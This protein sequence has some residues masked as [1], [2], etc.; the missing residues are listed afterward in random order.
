MRRIIIIIFVLV[1]VSAI[2]LP[3]FGQVS[4]AATIAYFPVIYGPP[5]EPPAW[6]GP[7]GGY[8]IAIAIAPSQP[9]TIY[10]G[11]WGSGVF[12]ST[13][14]GAT[15]V[16]KS[17]GLGTP[18]I[19]SMAVD[20][21]DPQTVYAGTYKGKVYKTIDGAEN[22]FQ[23]SKNIQAEAIVY[24]MVID[25]I[26]PE[27]IY[28]GTRGIANNGG[29]PWNGV[30]YRTTDA[31]ANWTAVLTNVG[32]S[33]D[34]DWAYGLTLH[35]RNPDWIYA[36][37][38]EHGVFRSTNSGLNWYA[39]NSGI[40]N[41]SARG[42]V[43]DPNSPKQDPIVYMGAWKFDG[44]FKTLN[45][46]ESWFFQS[47]SLGSRI[48]SMSIDPLDSENVYASLFPGGVL[49]TTNGGGNWSVA[50]LHD[51]EVASTVVNT[52]NTKLLYAGTNGDGLFMSVDRGNTW[53]HSQ[54][55][56]N[57]TRVSA[58]QVSA[59]NSQ[60]LFVG[61]YGD[62]L[63]QTWDGGESWSSLGSGL[64]GEKILGLETNPA[65]PNFLF[66]LTEA[67]GLYRCNLNSNCWLPISINFPSTALIQEPFTENHPFALPAL[68]EP[69]EEDEKQNPATTTQ[70]PPLLSL[71]FA[72]SNPQIAY[73][74]TS[75]AG[76]YKSSDNG[77]TWQP[78]SLTS[79]KIV[80][81]AVSSQDS[82]NVFV[83]TPGIVL[84][85]INGGL[86]WTNLNLNGLGIY[87]LTSDSST[88]IYAGTNDG[89]YRYSTSGWARLG[90]AGIDVTAIR[91]H[92]TKANHL[93]AGTTNGLYISHDGGQTWEARPWQLSGV[94][95]QSISFDLNAPNYVYVS[96]KTHGV[97]R[98]HDPY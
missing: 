33:S 21:K 56:L 9:N 37:T 87:V 50:G 44:V 79:E 42:V 32:G 81:I 3:T 67:G 94:T 47:S 75:G 25:P 93:Y 55:G 91:S 73:L 41:L 40:T 38:H 57:A 11:T 14:S 53:N 77:S 84:Q 17:H 30:L 83:A 5:P 35:P 76:L 64:T 68:L 34:Q 85:S 63:W 69:W 27:N 24:S 71:V 13:D 98:I 80:S 88:N 45:G 39:V 31:G 60:R 15:W 4:D 48:Y 43:V 62:G 89:V 16:W 19:N 96:T 8:I 49:K 70:I 65:D 6:I 28:I 78:T 26:D 54:K 58:M 97:M 23:S 82:E 7:Y 90:L 74:G 12:K 20:P 66:A 10:A 22:W 18:F 72:P 59:Y 51:L 29:P 2:V 52:V 61:I 1:S 86:N 95:I 36:A 92:P 46:G